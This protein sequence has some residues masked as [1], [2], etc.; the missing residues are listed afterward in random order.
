M[1][2]C[3]CVFVYSLVLSFSELD[4]PACIAS[5]ILVQF[6]RQLEEYLLSP[7]CECRVRL[8]LSN[9]DML[10]NLVNTALSSVHACGFG[11]D[12]R[13]ALC[14]N[15]LKVSLD[16]RTLWTAS[17]KASPAMFGLQLCETWCLSCTYCIFQDLT[18]T[19]VQC[20]FPT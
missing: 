15:L 5:C 18:S 4:I 11:G 8:D 13:Q 9:T 3:V 1:C 20:A 6:G 12:E 17:T 2:V 7:S 14:R 10:L 19:E 16:T